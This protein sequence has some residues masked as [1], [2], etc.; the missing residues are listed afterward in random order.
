MK[1]TRLVAGFLALGLLLALPL[2]CSG[3]E[4]TGWEAERKAGLVGE[5]AAGVILA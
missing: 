4:P 2:A 3:E 5:K 1:V